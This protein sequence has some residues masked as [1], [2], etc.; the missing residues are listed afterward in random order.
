MELFH[1]TSRHLIS[2]IL[3]EGLFPQLGERSSQCEEERAIFLFP[4]ME[5]LEYAVLN[6]FAD[7]VSEEVPLGVLKVT[8]PESWEKNIFIDPNVG[9]EAVCKV[10]IPPELIQEYYT[11]IEF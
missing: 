7:E 9:Y 10:P 3:Q 11:E 1:L 8:I 5:D 4:S 2:Q 6:W